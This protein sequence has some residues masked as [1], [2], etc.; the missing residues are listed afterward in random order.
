MASF[1]F[2]LSC[3]SALLGL[4]GP[5]IGSRLAACRA[6][7][8]TCEDPT[9]TFMAMRV[10][11][12]KA[13]LSR[14]GVAHDDLFEKEALARRLASSQHIRPVRAATQP[15]DVMSVQDVMA[16]LEARGVGF[17][18]LAPDS[19]LMAS[20]QQ[21]RLR[22]EPVPVKRRPASAARS[23]ASRQA[24]GRTPA[25]PPTPPPSPPSPPPPPA[26]AGGSPSQQ[27][28]P[29]EPVIG[30]TRGASRHRALLPLLG[31]TFNGAIELLAPAVEQLKP[32]T[33]TAVANAAKATAARAPSAR[34]VAAARASLRRMQL[35]PKP[36]ILVLCV[37]ALR[38][39]IT[40][41]VLV[42]VSVKLTLELIQEAADR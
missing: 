9:A 13:E 28:I 29:D 27:P 24:R 42:A 34:V 20:L 35:P 15:V 22:D 2:V 19:A 41:T 10:A 23:P 37:S 12:L 32:V 16:E 26:A 39:G 36:I 18:V 17:D 40:R 38:F 4:G 30:M 1:L 8:V 25:T 6:V 14:R 33:A 5:A 3:A 21:A 11:D 31:D 7:V